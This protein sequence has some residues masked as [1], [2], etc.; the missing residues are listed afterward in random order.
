MSVTPSQIRRLHMLLNHTGLMWQKQALIL[1]FTHDRSEHSRDMTPS[2]ISDMI[3]HLEGQSKDNDAVYRN[4]QMDKMRKKLLSYCYEM[5]WA[6]PGDWPAAIKKIDEFCSGKHGIYKK[7]LQK[8]TYEELV[9]VVTQ[10][11]TLYLKA[12]N[13]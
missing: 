11:G 4:K 6:D 12:L 2:E 13:K 5:R 8:H 10:F 7:A 1:S 3:S 9:N